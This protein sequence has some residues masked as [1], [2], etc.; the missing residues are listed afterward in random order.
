MNFEILF[1]LFI[2]GVMILSQVFKH[3]ARKAGKTEEKP[4]T[5]WRKGLENL[6]EEFSREMEGG[7][8]ASEIEKKPARH[9]N[10]WEDLM[11]EEIPAKETEGAQASLESNGEAASGE[12]VAAEQEKQWPKSAFRTWEPRSFAREAVPEKVKEIPHPAKRGRLSRRDLRRA[13]VWSE[14]L[15]P[16]AG[17]RGPKN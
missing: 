12:A 17:I 9:R 4:A 10:W 7:Q 2:V 8:E 16:P 1:F 6:L 13:V 3:M 14:I 11:S 5:G 15:A